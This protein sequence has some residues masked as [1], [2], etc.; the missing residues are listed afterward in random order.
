MSTRAARVGHDTTGP[1]GSPP[2]ANTP[3][4][5]SSPHTR[6]VLFQGVFG[7][8]GWELVTDTGEVLEESWFQSESREECIRDARER[9]SHASCDLP[10]PVPVRATP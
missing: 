10:R 3:P 6:V 1:T 4:T 7:G 8:W 9:L 2:P 5:P